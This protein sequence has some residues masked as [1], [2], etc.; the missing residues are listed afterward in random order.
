MRIISRN[1]RKKLR[2]EFNS[3]NICRINANHRINIFQSASK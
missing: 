1:I 3:D 2:Q